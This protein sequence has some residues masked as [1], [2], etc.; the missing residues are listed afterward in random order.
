MGLTNR[1][2]WMISDAA[3]PGGARR[4]HRSAFAIACEQVALRC[5]GLS[6][7]GF[8]L[9]QLGCVHRLPEDRFGS[10]RGRSD[11]PAGIGR[12]STELRFAPE[13]RQAATLRRG[14]YFSSGIFPIRKSCCARWRSFHSSV[15][16]ER[17]RVVVSNPQGRGRL[18]I[19]ADSSAR[20]SLRCSGGILPKWRCFTSHLAGALRWRARGVDQCGC[21]HHRDCRTKPARAVAGAGAAGSDLPLSENPD[22]SLMQRAAP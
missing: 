7:D 5:A 21:G 16:A 19:L 12:A 9:E 20:R 4:L 8:A 6:P 22:R 18:L 14:C 3:L 10:C 17:D 11:R 2:G 15:C 13:P 1:A